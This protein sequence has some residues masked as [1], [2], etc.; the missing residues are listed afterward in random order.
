VPSCCCLARALTDLEA[1]ERA[2]GTRTIGPGGAADAGDELTVSA[3]R[4]GDVGFGELVAE[5]ILVPGC[6]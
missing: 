2:T 3:R 5:G 6:F 1:R 4:D